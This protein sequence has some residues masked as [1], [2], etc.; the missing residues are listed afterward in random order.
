MVEFGKL[1][2]GTMASSVP[3]QLLNIIILQRQSDFIEAYEVYQK[4]LTKETVSVSDFPR[5]RARLISLF[6]HCQPGLKRDGLFFN[7]RDAEYKSYDKF[8]KALFGLDIGQDEE[9]LNLL[10][11]LNEWIDFKGVT[12]FDTNPNYDFGDVE[13]ENAV[14]GVG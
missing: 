1:S 8:K 14:N 4:N 13:A 7:R 11:F 9:L 3:K 5:V 2:E 10:F 12:K 6:I